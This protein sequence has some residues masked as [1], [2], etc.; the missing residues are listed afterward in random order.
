MIELL[1]Q[2]VK[3]HVITGHSWWPDQHGRGH[4][5]LERIGSLVVI[6]KFDIR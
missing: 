6:I 3:G 2:L 1:S 4:L 5:Y